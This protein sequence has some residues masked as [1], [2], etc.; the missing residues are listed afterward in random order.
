MTMRSESCTSDVMAYKDIFFLDAIKRQLKT[1]NNS[2]EYANKLIQPLREYDD[3][4]KSSLAETL[5][6]LLYN[7]VDI[8]TSAKQLYTHRNT[9][10]YRR[11]RIIEVLGKSPF[12]MPYKLNYLVAFSILTD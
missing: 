10:L 9:I 12:E 2:V 7:D 1:N 4:H 11:N 3:T 5:K 8:A 6:V